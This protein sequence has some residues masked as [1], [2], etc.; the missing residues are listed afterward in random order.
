[1]IDDLTRSFTID[2]VTLAWDR[3]GPGGDGAPLLL[4][5]GF[6]G[7]SHDFALH[8]EPLAT[9]REVVTIDHRGHGR[10][11]KLASTDRYSIDRLV[12]DVIAFID[13]EVGRPVNLLG[14]SMGGAIS[15]RVTLDRPDLVQSLILMDTSAW[16]FVP[17]SPEIAELMAA[18]IEGF[19]PA[20]G[21]PDLSMMP[22]PEDPLIAAATPA[23][24]QAMKAEMAAAFDPYAMKALGRALFEPSGSSVRHRLGEIAC[25]VSVIVGEHDHPFVDQAP[26][27]VAELADGTLTVFAGAYHS[28]QL[29][30]PAEWAAAVAAHLDRVAR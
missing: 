15:L 25:P 9:A 17:P 11:Q 4:C 26:E 1:M 23:E 30:H 3:W 5:H 16:S 13:S 20:G 8:I 22:N 28:P 6:S 27:L 10:S 21:L 2:D 14:H 19:D 12:A 29:T 7:S 18:F 24:W